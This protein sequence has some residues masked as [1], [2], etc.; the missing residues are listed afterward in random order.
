MNSTMTD[1]YIKARKEYD[2]VTHNINASK[3]NWQRMAFVLTFLLIISMVSNIYTIKKAHV[4]PYIVEVDNLGRAM[5]VNEAK[6]IP[7]NDER[8]IKAFA[9][10]YIDMAR[11]IISDP[12]ALRKN[13][14]LVYQESVKSVQNNFLDLYYKDNNPFDYA[15]NKG[16]RHVQFLVFLKEAENTYAVEWKELERNYDNQVLE[17]GHYKA[18]ISIIQIPL[19]QEDQ[20]KGNPFNPFGLYVTS[21]SWSKLM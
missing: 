6:D 4:I 5:A 20:Y 3:H 21:L 16:T 19:A 11:S 9:Y 2:E 18:L 15:Q 1:P 13:L 14:S 8:I 12:E 10:Q 7:V 17:E